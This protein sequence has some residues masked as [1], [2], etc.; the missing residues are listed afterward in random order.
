MKKY[1]I[2]SFALFFSCIN[3]V[4]ACDADT[5]ILSFIDEPKL[6]SIVCAKGSAY[7]PNRKY[8]GS[9]GHGWYHPNG[10]YA[11]SKTG[12]WYHSNGRYAGSAGGGW[13]HSNGR[14][15][16]SVGGGWYYSNG[17]YA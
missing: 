8:A 14:Y 2:L 12:G 7:Y 11:G 13:Y 5:S 15:A 17:E 16:G 9:P 10:R 3:M 4:F 6:A 1:L